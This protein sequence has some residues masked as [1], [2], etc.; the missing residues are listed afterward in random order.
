ML[1]IFIFSFKKTHQIKNKN[2]QIFKSN[3]LQ[4]EDKNK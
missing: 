1:K 2:I 4:E 3:Q